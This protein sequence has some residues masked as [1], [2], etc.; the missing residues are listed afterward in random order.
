M[1]LAELA[2]IEAIKQLKYKY[3]RCVDMKLW[4][5]L[6]ETFIA[7]ATCSYSAGHY[8]YEGRD[9]IIAWMKKGM[10]RDGFHSSHSVHH[11]E[12]TLLAAE[13]AANDTWEKAKG[14]WALEDIVID[15][16][17]DIQISGAAFYEDRYVKDEGVWLIEHTGYD[18]VF[19][20][21][22]SR[23]DR[24]SLKLTASMWSTGGASS[25]EA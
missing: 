20:Q 15:T 19:E 11:P 23:A 4:D 16:D 10:D 17:H 13:D 24:P 6:A 7:E 22:E 18:R 1:N 9:A 8:S 5:E 14:V 25:I 2:E 12:I 21:M 3:M